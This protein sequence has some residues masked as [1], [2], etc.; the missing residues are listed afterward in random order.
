[1]QYNATYAASSADI[2][3]VR[4]FAKEFGLTVAD[5]STQ[6]LTVLLTGT[7]AA[8]RKAFCVSLRQATL[9]GSTYRVRDSAIH[10]PAGLSDIVVAVLGLDDR[11]QAN[12]PFR[13]FNATRQTRNPP[14]RLS[15]QYLIHACTDRP[16][17]PIPNRRHCGRTAIGIIELGGGFRQADITAYF[18]T[19]GIVAPT[20]SLVFVDNGTNAPTTS[21]GAD[22]EVML[23]IEIAAAVAPG[24]NI[25]VHFAPNSHQGFIDA[26]STAVH[27]P[28]SKPGVISIS[29][30][31]PE[32]S[33]TQQSMTAL[34]QACQSSAALG[35]T[36]TVAA[37]DNG[38]TDGVTD[39][40]NHV[41]FPSSSSH[42]L[43]RGGTKLIGSH[44]AITSEVVWNETANNEGATG[45]GVSSVFS[46]PT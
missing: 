5:S 21:S 12:P 43:A 44:S 37:G 3:Q 10:L 28:A 25:V 46:R 22:G 8:M 16:A 7:I 38:S 24:A 41:D 15:C 35:I 39:G 40:A 31:A 13:V 19:L 27:D 23:D 18:K 30:G 6:R 4:K 32:S 14:Q 2:A 34:N 9:D 11:L 33:W 45:G 17:L 29:W 26:I 1:M 20:V 36:I 42:V